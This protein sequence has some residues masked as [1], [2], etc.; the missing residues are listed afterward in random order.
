MKL[1]TALMLSLAFA[2]A[3][4]ARAQDYTYNCQ[5]FGSFDTY[6][7]QINDMMAMITSPFEGTRMGYGN[8]NGSYQFSGPLQIGNSTFMQAVLEVPMG[9]IGAS[10]LSA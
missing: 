1:F 3:S 10:Y 4:N 5:S 7:L 2:T 8:S 9:M 6:Q